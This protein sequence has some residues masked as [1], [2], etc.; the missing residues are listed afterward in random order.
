MRIVRYSLAVLGLLAVV[1]IV[2]YPS[3][4]AV[5]PTNPALAAT[6]G[7]AGL[8][9][10]FGLMTLSG[11]AWVSLKSLTPPGEYL[12]RAQRNDVNPTQRGQTW[13]A[14]KELRDRAELW[15]LR[16]DF[17]RTVVE[18]IAT[19]AATSILTGLLGLLRIRR[20]PAAS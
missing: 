15:R 10:Q 11:N 3:K 16:V 19:F 12:V 2:L 4:I 7:R 18:V 8:W 5:H 17:R 20:E 6:Y 1:G 9:E 13:R 14:L